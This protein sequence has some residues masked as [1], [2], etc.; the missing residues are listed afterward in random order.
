MQYHQNLSAWLILCFLALK[1]KPCD[2]M[3]AAQRIANN[4]N[5]IWYAYMKRKAAS[6]VQC[7]W[8]RGDSPAC[9]CD[10]TNR[11][12]SDYLFSIDVAPIAENGTC[13]R[14]EY[15]VAFLVEA[16]MCL[17]L[18]LTWAQSEEAHHQSIR[19]SFARSWGCAQNL[20][21][22]PCDST[23]DNEALSGMAL[24]HLEI[25]IPWN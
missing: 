19:V 16:I 20:C 22:F 25:N 8:A 24:R 10:Y 21:L 3:C 5:F 4:R 6:S 18:Y 7:K 11:S 14:D 17:A 1:D 9:V 23:F 13:V 2:M 12:L 15:S